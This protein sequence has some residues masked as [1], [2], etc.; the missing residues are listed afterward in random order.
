MIELASFGQAEQAL[1]RAVTS[2]LHSRLFRFGNLGLLGFATR[3]SSSRM[4]LSLP[5]F[6]RWAFRRIRVILVTVRTVV[7]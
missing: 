6:F 7:R 5:P 3:R 1:M 2:P 4:G